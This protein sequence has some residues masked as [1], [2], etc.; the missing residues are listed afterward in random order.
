MENF[1][2]DPQLL[3]SLG[4][5]ARGLSA[6]FWGLPATLIICAETARME[7]LQPFEIVPALVANLILLFGLWQM[8]NF[9]KQERPWRNALDRAKLLGLINLGLCPFLFWFNRLPQ[10]DY[11]R[12]TILVLVLSALLFLLN[13]N[14]ALKQ[15]GAMLPDET[16]RH[17]I[18]QFTQL[19]RWLLTAFLIFI[20]VGVWIGIQ[21]PN[22]DPQHVGEKNWDIMYR[23]NIAIS[24]FLGLSPLAITMALI[25]KTKEV[26]FDSVFGAK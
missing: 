6:I 15:L 19:N 22:F 7:S 10:V 11:F 23:M 8:S 25:W 13:L 5:L 24:L 4:K 21:F 20:I 1:T 14:V 17:D 3:R 26:I 16:L 2:P 9:Q 18:N 12:A